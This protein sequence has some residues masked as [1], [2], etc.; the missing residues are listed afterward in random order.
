MKGG[1]G[2]FC[3]IA[4]A[5]EVLAE[6]WTPLVVRELVMG[7]TRFNDIRRG[8]PLMSPSLLAK[9]LRTLEEAGIVERVADSDG[10]NVEYRLTLAGQEL[11]PILQLIGMWGARWVESTVDP[12]DLDA[13]LLMWDIRRTL[14][15]GLLT[16]R[17][18]RVVVQFR[19]TDGPKGKRLWWL[20]AEPEGAQLCLTDPG[21]EV[22]MV[23]T[24]DLCSLTRVWV[25]DLEM[26]AALREGL[27][28]AQGDTRLVESFPRWLR[29]SPFARA[30]RAAL[31][32]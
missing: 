5:C 10:R 32:A 7:S 28:R 2:Q 31:N 20:V 8:V 24:C 13:G 17:R 30:R 26:E 11:Q 19:F 25:G 27:I 9:R 18:D 3:P 29:E 1:Y 14:D 12:Q 4:K 21:L 23:V 22:D 16:G 6:R 15:A